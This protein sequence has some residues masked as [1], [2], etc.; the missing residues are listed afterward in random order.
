MKNY[1]F[2]DPSEFAPQ[3]MDFIINGEVAEIILLNKPSVSAEVIKQNNKLNLVL[4][5]KIVKQAVKFKTIEKYI[6][7]I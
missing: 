2:T 5:G 6:N 7:K 4:N 1:K 3:V